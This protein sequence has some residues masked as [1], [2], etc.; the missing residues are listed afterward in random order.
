MI[1]N[2]VV[3]QNLYRISVPAIREQ[4]QNGGAYSFA[5]QVN[6]LI[7]DG[8]LSDESLAEIDSVFDPALKSIWWACLGISLVSLLAVCVERGLELRKELDT[9]YGLEVE[10][11]QDPELKGAKQ[12]DETTPKRASA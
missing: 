10:K 7:Q 5:S 6:G 12:Q 1:F 4:M 3:D 2:A 8:T 11:C 9:D